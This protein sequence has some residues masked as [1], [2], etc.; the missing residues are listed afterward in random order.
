MLFCKNFLTAYAAEAVSF[1]GKRDVKPPAGS[2]GGA[3]QTKPHEIYMHLFTCSAADTG[4][5]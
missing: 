3:A 1:G 5:K 4:H 2:A